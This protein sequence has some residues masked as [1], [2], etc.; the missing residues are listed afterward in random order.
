M[1]LELA[2]NHKPDVILL[3]I[4]LPDMDGKEVFKNL[5]A[6]EKTS[7]I[8]V[9]ALSADAMES[10]I[11]EVLNLGFTSY[12]TKPIDVADVFRRIDEALA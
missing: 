2:Q 10:D 9:I 4:H 1:G 8:P 7:A 6:N 3:D 12:I 5:K 11:K